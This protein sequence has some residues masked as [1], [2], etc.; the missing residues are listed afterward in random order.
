[1]MRAPQDVVVVSQEELLPSLLQVQNNPHASYEVHQLVLLGV[2][3]V[4]STLVPPV[5]IYP[6]QAEL[7]LWKGSV[8]IS[9]GAGAS[10]DNEIN[11]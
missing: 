2:K 4:V 11:N 1:M 6:L 9:H 10:R 3:E 5:T 8:P 7:A